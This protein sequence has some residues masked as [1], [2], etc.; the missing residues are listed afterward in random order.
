MTE[1]FTECIKKVG[2]FIFHGELFSVGPKSA[3]QCNKLPVNPNCTLLQT[4]SVHPITV[5]GSE[6]ER[7]GRGESEGGVTGER[8]GCLCT[9]TAGIYGLRNNL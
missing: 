6:R 5:S 2:K 9:I 1:R 7:E 3:P 4:I 8:E